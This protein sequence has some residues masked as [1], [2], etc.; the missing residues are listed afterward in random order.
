MAE[1][2]YVTTPI[3]YVND[4]PHIGHAYT[5][6]AADVLARFERMRGKKVRFLTGTDEH[7][8]KIQQAARDKGVTPQALADAVVEHYKV[9]WPK[10]GISY[11]DFIRTTEARHKRGVAALWRRVAEKGDLYLGEYEGWYCTPDETYVADDEL[12]PNNTCPHCGRPVE[13]VKEASWFFRLSKYRERLVAHIGANPSFIGPETRR[14]EILGFLREPLRDL[15][16]SRTTFDWGIPVPD[17]PGHVVYVWFDALANYISALGYPDESGDFAAFWPADVHL[18]GKDILRFH[19]V[20]WPAFLMS[21]GLPVPKRVFAHG[22]WTVNGQKMSKSLRNAVDPA[23]LADA[24]GADALRYFLLREAAFGQDGD[25]AIAN[26]HARINT[27]LAND[28]GNLLSRAT[29]MAQKYAEGRVARPEE[30]PEDPSDRK[31][32]AAHAEA[33]RAAE[34]HVPAC[35]F[36]KALMAIWD[37][38]RAGNKYVDETTPWALAKAAKGEAVHARRLAAVLYNLAECLRASAVLLHPFMP[39]KTAEMWAALGMPGR[40]EDQR[41]DAVRAW[42]GFEASVLTKAPVLFPKVEIAEGEK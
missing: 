21:A 34:E 36:N 30:K 28:L 23:M 11:D 16:V 10:L 40:I 29:S 32:V 37:F 19:A 35:A 9:L 38:V 12:G 20:F 7:G 6:V 1:T 4:H 26:L 14:N 17:A 24:Y 13:R 41:F 3:Y 2:F 22:W 39:G 27:D 8:Q 15:S 42:G 5:T 25:F 31:L 33:V 18:I